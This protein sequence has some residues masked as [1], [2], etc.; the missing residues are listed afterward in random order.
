MNR[1]T[2]KHLEFK[3]ERINTAMDTPQQP[4]TQ[5]DSGHKPNARCYHLSYAYGGVALHQMCD[6]GTGIHDISRQ[7]HVTK[8]ELANFMDGMLAGVA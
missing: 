3:V 4:Y 7:G 8:R 6:E 1:I 5:T 2:N